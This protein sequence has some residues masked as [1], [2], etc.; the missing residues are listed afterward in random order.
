MGFPSVTPHLLMTLSVGSISD[1]H[2]RNYSKVTFEMMKDQL[3]K[4]NIIF[5]CAYLHSAKT[6]DLKAEIHVN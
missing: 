6:I 4:L 2:F 5:P 1:R 3:C